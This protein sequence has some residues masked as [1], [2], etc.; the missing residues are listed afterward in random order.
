MQTQKQK[1]LVY[2]ADSSR[3]LI[4]SKTENERTHV[5]PEIPIQVTKVEMFC[6]WKLK[7]CHF[8]PNLSKNEQQKKGDM[9]RLT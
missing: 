4:S 7:V 1:Q 3:L 8:E 2:T 5:P 6:I 9:H